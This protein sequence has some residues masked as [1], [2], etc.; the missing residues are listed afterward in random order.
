MSTP[1][2]ETLRA[3][4]IAH[5]VARFSPALDAAEAA[6]ALGLPP[7]A[8]LKTLAAVSMPQVVLACLAIDRRLDLAALARH[9]GEPRT[10]LVGAAALERMTGFAAGA[11]TPIPLAGGRRFRVLIDEAALAW[12][13][14]AVGAGAPGTEVLLK[15]AELV[16]VCDAGIAPIAA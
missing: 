5:R 12:P 4:G 2:I 7:A 13:E 9:L 14:I 11:V 8:M 16:A 10:A 3:A 6:A 15:P 1:A